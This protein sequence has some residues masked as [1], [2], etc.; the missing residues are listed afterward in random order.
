MGLIVQGVAYVRDVALLGLG[1]L[2]ESVL[3]WPFGLWLSV[4]LW[5]YGL[6]GLGLEVYL[7]VHGT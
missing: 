5:G 1:L 4:A 7:E 6:F 3:M 2:Q